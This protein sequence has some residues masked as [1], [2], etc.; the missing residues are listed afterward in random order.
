MRSNRGPESSEF[1]FIQNNLYKSIEHIAAR[2]SHVPQHSEPQHK[3]EIT[4]AI[5]DTGKG[6]KSVCSVSML[7]S[8]NDTRRHMSIFFLLLSSPFS[9]PTPYICVLQ[10]LSYMENSFLL[11]STE[12]QT[13]EKFKKMIH[14]TLN[15][16]SPQVNNSIH[17]LAN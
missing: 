7:S 16:F 11:D 5:L 15:S 3:R 6:E 10:D 1:R 14:T 9:F 4:R 8:P 12:R 2:C 13:S 17:I